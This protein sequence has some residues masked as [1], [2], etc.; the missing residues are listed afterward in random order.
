MLYCESDFDINTME[1]AGIY[2]RHYRCFHNQFFSLHPLIKGFVRNDRHQSVK[3]LKTDDFDLF[4]ERK[5]N[6]KVLCGKNGSGKSTLIQLIRHDDV[7]KNCCVLI[8]MDASERI[9]ASNEINVE[10]KGRMCLLQNKKEFSIATD[11]NA[12]KPYDDN[13]EEICFWNTFVYRYLDTPELFSFKNDG[14]LLTHYEIQLKKD[15]VRT[16]VAPFF[17]KKM[18]IDYHIISLDYYVKYPL[19]LLIAFELQ[20][21]IYEDLADSINFNSEN[22]FVKCIDKNFPQVARYN[23]ELQN[24]LFNKDYSTNSIIT[25]IPYKIYKLTTKE[26]IIKNYNLLEKILDKTRDSI[27]FQELDIDFFSFTPLKIIGQDKRYLHDLSDGERSRL[28]NRQKIHTSLWQVRDSKGYQVCFD[29]PEMH[30]HPEMSRFFWMNLIKEIE[31]T[32][33]FEYKRIEALKGLTDSQKKEMKKIIRKRFFT[34][35]VATHNPFL[36]SDLFRQNILALEKNKN[37]QI[38]EIE[39]KNT[40]AGNIAEILCDSMFMEGMIGAFA[41]DEI[42][43]LLRKSSDVKNNERK[44]MLIE[45]ISDPLLKAALT[46]EVSL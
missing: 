33:N 14:D 1:L 17:A 37:G 41:E 38:Q 6:V 43:K 15:F 39:I 10:F 40:F 12:A 46:S 20:D 34:V 5:I 4:R 24:I 29:E 19:Y 23:K 16:Y 31:F 26:D 44:R 42:K 22:G 30:Y 45:R 9:A 2:I 27:G 11:L 32:R 35:I 25:E 28:Y 36:L 18:G 13:E 3:L 21:V 7:P 8:F